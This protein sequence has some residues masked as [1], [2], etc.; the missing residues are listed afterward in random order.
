MSP[1]QSDVVGTTAVRAG[2]AAGNRAKL[3][4]GNPWPG[5]GAYGEDSTDFFKG[6]EEETAELLRLIRLTPL[7]V[8]YSKSGLGKT[9]LL[10]AGLFPLL[11][12]GHFLPV[13][14][15]LDFSGGWAIP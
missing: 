10:E 3:D 12:A 5:L 6:R 1:S 2:R 13:Y 11:R 9:F 7:T 8:L 4:P 14:L 15:R